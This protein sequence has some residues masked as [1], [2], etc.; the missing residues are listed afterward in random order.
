M[1]K[2]ILVVLVLLINSYAYDDYEEP[3]DEQPLNKPKKYV[4]RYIDSY[5]VYE[6]P[7]E[8][9]SNV[10]KDEYEQ[11]IE[12]QKQNIKEKEKVDENI[13]DDGIEIDIKTPS[14]EIDENKDSHLEDSFKIDDKDVDEVL[15][16]EV[17]TDKD[18]NE[19]TLFDEDEYDKNS[20]KTKQIKDEDDIYQEAIE[21]KPMIKQRVKR[22]V[23]RVEKKEKDDDF[24]DIYGLD[25]I[26]TKVDDNLYKKEDIV[27]QNIEE[28]IVDI[29]DDM[30]KPE[31]NQEVEINSE[32][33]TKEIEQELKTV[34][35]L[36]SDNDNIDDSKDLCPDTPLG[37]EV[38]KTGCPFDSDADGVYDYKDRCSNT[39][40]R[41]KVDKF[42]CEVKRVAKKILK[43]KFEKNSTRLT[44]NSF[45]E[46]LRFS[47]FL[48]KYPK[49]DAQIIA[50]TDNDRGI[51]LAR[52]RA[53][54]IKEALIIEG[55]DASRLEVFAYSK[56]II[57]KHN[58]D[59]NTIIEVKILY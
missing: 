8:V 48:K 59:I 42:G 40:L 21:E 26:D 32:A 51:K 55:I 15:Y 12:H 16:N 23:N 38:D 49:Y 36:D 45:S 22:E 43:V 13:I 17:D 3:I 57:T 58:K 18:S 27:D 30:I 6:K 37:V 44:Y 54:A 11:P 19:D 56:N 41:A 39:P 34:E 9:T 47:D 31:D 14:K 10:D 24:N 35:V 1:I 25:E 53:K 52:D 4:G 46:V 28:P 20:L 33:D 29:Q 2:K 7:I 50:Y 5:E